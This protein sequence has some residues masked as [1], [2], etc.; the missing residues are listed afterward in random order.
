MDRA[1]AHDHS[2]QPN[3]FPGCTF[4]DMENTIHSVTEIITR[5]IDTIANT[6]LLRKRLT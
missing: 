1:T 6:E 5:D 2:R 3:P 4:P